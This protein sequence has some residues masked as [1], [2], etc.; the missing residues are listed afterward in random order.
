MS[1]HLSSAEHHEECVER[2]DYVKGLV[3]AFLL[4]IIAFAIV[5][6]KLLSSPATLLLLGALALIQGA[7]QVRYFLHV[8]TRSHRDDLLLI[9]FTVLIAAIVVGGTIWILWDQHMRMM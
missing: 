5:W 4:T 2:R 1:Q 9:L 7:V 6:L 3:L 8:D